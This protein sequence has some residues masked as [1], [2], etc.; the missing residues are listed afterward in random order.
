MA[1]RRC[2]GLAGGSGGGPEMSLQ[3][4]GEMHSCVWVWLWLWLWLWLCLWLW[5]RGLASASASASGWACAADAVLLSR[6]CH[7]DG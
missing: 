4:R 3:P 5:V 2:L 6:A 7:P 1:G